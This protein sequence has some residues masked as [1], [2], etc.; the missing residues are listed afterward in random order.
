MNDNDSKNE[1]A[2]I[3][4]FFFAIALML[5]FYLLSP[6]IFIVKIIHQLA[7]GLI[8]KTSAF[9]I[10]VSILYASI[11]FFLEKRNGVSNIRVRS[12]VLL[13][14]LL[15]ALLA[16]CTMDFTYFRELSLNAKG[17]YSAFKAIKLLWTSGINSAEI[18]PMTNGK[19]ILS[20][21][22]LGGGIAVAFTRVMGKVISIMFL[23]LLLLSQIILMFKIS[24]KK[25]AKKAASKAASTINQVR[26][27]TRP[28]PQ[29]RPQMRPMQRP[30]QA[31]KAN[32]PAPNSFVNNA[33]TP[34]GRQIMENT[35][36]STD[37]FRRSAFPVNPDNGFA[38]L[39]SREYGVEAAG[40]D[41]M[42]SYGNNVVSTS[43]SYDAPSAD[44][45]Y[46]A[47]PKN[48]RLRP[49]KEEQKRPSFLPDNTQE[50]FYSLE[51]ATYVNQEQPINQ[52][53]YAPVDIDDEPYEIT[54]D[55][56]YN[57]EPREYQVRMPNVGAV[58]E[59]NYDYSAQ[60]LAP[61]AP[62]P[63]VSQM[64]QPVEQPV[65]DETVEERSDITINAESASASGY[66]STEGRIIETSKSNN[67][68]PTLEIGTTKPVVDTHANN[69][70]VI[71]RRM[72]SYVKPSTRLLAPDDAPKANAN[73]S[74]ELKEKAMKLEETIRSFGIETKVVN[75]T[76]G[77]AITRFELQ[78]MKAGTKVSRILNLQDDIALSMAAFSVRIEAPI[79]GTSCIGIELPNEKTSA[80]YLRSL[81]ESKEFR[82]APPLT[83]PLGR[84]I[85]GKPIMCNLAKMPHLL[86]AGS[87]GS[88]KSVCIN[89]I[90]TSILYNSS[91]EDVRMILVDPKVVELSIYNGIPH[92]IMPVVTQPKKAAGALKWAV[93]EMERRYKC[94][95]ESGV[96]DLAGYNEWLKFR[97]EK[98][99]PLILIVID[100]LADL[101]TVAAKEVEDHISRLAAMA[102]AAGLH[103]IIATQRPSVDVITGV[104]KANVPSRIAFA[105]SSGVDSRTILDSV[106]AEKLL[107]KGDMLYAP[108]SAP[109]PVRGQGAFLSD[110]EVENV[111]KY[112]K[113]TFG[114]YYDEDIIKAI[115]SVTEGGSG[116]GAAM[117]GDG[118]DGD[119]EDDLL[120]RAVET[121]IDA[122]N[123][124]VSILQRRLGIGYPRAARLIDVLEQKHYIG[125]FEGSKPRKVL[126]N[127]TD[128][129]E[130]KAKGNN[131]Q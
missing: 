103:M 6:E 33:A 115:D 4:L 52:D 18:S 56:P 121:V 34:Y 38:D 36:V 41:G 76:H 130:I 53:D 88:G 10:P 40:N 5:I 127:R 125:P 11:D 119:G 63:V 97:G 78:L 112:L 25:T 107:G 77:P 113:D 128:W 126:I 64:P 123:A 32:T 82:A 94:F 24:L 54:D 62:S 124:S 84:D 31:N 71:S 111:V 100:E 110:K 83:V 114:P 129:L 48:P 66:S 102:R 99:L 26:R 95:A 29:A 43:E 55:D 35:Q 14:I 37:P 92:L 106:G 59:A 65:V 8:G 91:Y 60:V 68:V 73:N 23:V 85:P 80:V 19:T 70:K 28:M 7:F 75:I 50:D 69:G 2:G 45:S 67:V 3:I 15:S 39:S 17:K 44:F 89:T 86:I 1:I 98:P 131:G 87:T 20:G 16:V 90:L 101:M 51:G 9:L 21:G 93:Q 22:I 58:P 120:E 74:Q 117:G 61:V 118:G 116:S 13:V 49:H 105:V 109:K 46:T 104:I 96:R 12:V 57:F 27:N 108:L 30:V 81:I 47:N 42:L 72:K 122:G 79:P